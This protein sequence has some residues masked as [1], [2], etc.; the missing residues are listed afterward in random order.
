MLPVRELL[1]GLNGYTCGVMLGGF[2][3]FATALMVLL[4]LAAF[5]ALT[6]FGAILWT[7][8][9]MGVA[10]RQSLPRR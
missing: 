9:R 2:R 8:A 4:V 6:V 5:L 7:F 10:P 3:M 1:A